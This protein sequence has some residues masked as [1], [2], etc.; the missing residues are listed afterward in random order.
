[1]CVNVFIDG[2]RDSNDGE[3]RV[4]VHACTKNYLRCKKCEVHKCVRKHVIRC[5]EKRVPGFLFLKALSFPEFT[6]IQ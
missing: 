3:V 4:S 2:E 5:T 1:M 6:Q